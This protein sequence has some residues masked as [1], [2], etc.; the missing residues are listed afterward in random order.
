MIDLTGRVALVTGGSRGIGRACALRLAK[1]NSRV[2]DKRYFEGLPCPSAAAPSVG[3]VSHAEGLVGK[4]ERPRK[5]RCC[6]HA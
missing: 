2:Q 1:F 4:W 3:G 6:F 5:P